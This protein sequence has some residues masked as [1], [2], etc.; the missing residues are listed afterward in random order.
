M[1]NQ[2]IW[3]VQTNTDTSGSAKPTSLPL[4]NHGKTGD[5]TPTAEN[6]ISRA[7]DVSIERMHMLLGYSRYSVTN[8]APTNHV[9]RHDHRS[10]CLGVICGV[11]LTAK[12]ASLDIPCKLI[13]DRPNRSDPFTCWT[14][15]SSLLFGTHFNTPTSNFIP[16]PISRIPWFFISLSF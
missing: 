2:D 11:K 15:R 4:S 8:D 12:R 5:I 14:C 6:Q 1:A 10:A 3:A 13:A 9:L 7:K 16:H